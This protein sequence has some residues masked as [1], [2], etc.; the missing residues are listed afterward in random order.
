[1]QPLTFD[2]VLHWD[3][4]AIHQAFQVANKRARTLHTLGENLAAVQK[5][6]LEHWG[7]C[8]PSLRMTVT[9]SR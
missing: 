2:D 1:M 6:A 9:A 3:S 8:W 4:G 5:R 7:G